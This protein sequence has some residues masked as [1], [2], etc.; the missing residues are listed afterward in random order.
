MQKKTLKVLHASLLGLFVLVFP[1]LLLGQTMNSASYQIRFDSL[2]SGGDFASSTSYQIQDTFGEVATG[3]SVSAPSNWFDSNWGH[4]VKVTIRSSQVPVTLAQ[5]PLYV[6]LSHLP[7]VFFDRVQ[8]NGADVRV[9]EADGVTETPFEVAYINTTNKTGELFV[10]IDSLSA[11][12]DTEFYI[13]YNNP[14]AVA[15]A[16]SDTYGY[17]NVWSNYYAVFHLNEDANTS[18]GGYKNSAGHGGDGTGNSMD[19]PAT[20][21]GAYAGPAAELDGINDRISF[22]ST[23]ASENSVTL[24]AWTYTTSLQNNLAALLLSRSSSYVSLVESGGAVDHITTSWGA[25]IAHYNA[26]TNLVIPQNQWNFVAGVVTPTTVTTYLNDQT[27][28]VSAGGSWSPS[29][30]YIGW[31][32]V[33][34]SRHW[35]GLVDEVRIAKDSLSADWLALEQFNQRFPRVLYSVHDEESNAGSYVLG[36]GFQQM[37]ETYLAMSV[38]N[39][40]ILEPGVGILADNSV[41]QEE[42]LIRTDSVAGYNIYVRSVSSPALQNTGSG[43]DFSDYTPVSVATPDNWSIDIGNREFGFSVFDNSGHV[44]D[45][46]WG[47]ADNCGNTSTGDPDFPGGSEQYYDALSTTDR[48]V[49]QSSTRTS[50]IGNEITFCFAA[51]RNNALVE[52]GFYQA[53]IIVTAVA[54]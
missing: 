13:Y 35:D 40:V 26:V 31:D 2:N 3:R 37:N 1:F 15:Y 50:A 10:L 25:V 47:D 8:A 44:D 7:T 23:L 22:T 46:V 32:S 20:T 9:T 48:L 28:S 33:S 11:V 49:A 34:T 53:N 4:R 39:D 27:F 41:G 38:I 6:D 30:W 21:T 12:S 29:L 51:G 36:A 5:Y 43:P 52:E 14:G 18:A 45:L 42:L 24:S 54:L 17:E 16:G 19:L